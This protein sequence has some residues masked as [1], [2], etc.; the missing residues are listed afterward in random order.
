MHEHYEFHLHV[1][2][3]PCRCRQRLQVTHIHAQSAHGHL[4]YTHDMDEKQPER[5]AHHLGAD[6]WRTSSHL[7]AEK[8]ETYWTTIYTLVPRLAAC[9][10]VPAHVRESLSANA[11]QTRR[12]TATPANQDVMQSQSCRI[13]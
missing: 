8:Q 6:P 11:P 5:S 10:L 3:T 4:L 13:V 1:L 9:V 7:L 2:Q 12:F